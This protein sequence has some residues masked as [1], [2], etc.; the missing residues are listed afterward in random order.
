M[1][2][3]KAKPH[4]LKVLFLPSSDLYPKQKKK[5]AEISSLFL[6]AFRLI[7]MKNDRLQNALQ[8]VKIIEKLSGLERD[9]HHNE[10]VG[11]FAVF[12]AADRHVLVIFV[13]NHF[14]G[15]LGGEQHLSYLFGGVFAPDTV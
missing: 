9:Y 7:S 6:F 10:P 11:D 8:T 13:H 1:H 12:K 2:L 5:T 14:F 3:K 4:R 15:I